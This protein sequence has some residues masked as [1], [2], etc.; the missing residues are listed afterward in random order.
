[1][2]QRLGFEVET[3][4][5]E[6]GEGVPLDRYVRCSRRTR[7][8]KIKAVLAVRTRRRPASRAIWR[9]SAGRSMPRSIRRC[10]MSTT[11]SALAS[12]DFR[13]DEWGVDSAVSGSQKGLMLPAGLAVTGREPE[14]ARGREN[15]AHASAAISIYADMI[16]CQ[17]HRLLPLH[18]RDADAVR[19]A[20]GAADLIEEEGLE[21]I[22]HRHSYI[23]GGVRAAVTRGLEA[24][25]V[26]HVRRSGTPTR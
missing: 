5:V 16:S 23:A 4:E 8:H 17:C 10:S 19:P 22:F 7:K 21:N 1:M 26:R 24:Q 25:A 9:Q 12:I 6:W 13:M 14:G 20:R 18:A 11:V 3:L 2:C 15:R